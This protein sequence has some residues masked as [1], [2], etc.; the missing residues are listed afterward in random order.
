MDKVSTNNISV[1]GNSITK[2]VRLYNIYSI[3]P[4]RENLFQNGHTVSIIS[5]GRSLYMNKR[6]VFNSDD[7]IIYQI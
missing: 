5:Y 2:A 7:E 6:I 4:R 1:I 3:A